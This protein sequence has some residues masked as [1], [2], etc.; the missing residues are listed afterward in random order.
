VIVG[1]A[2]PRC[3]IAAGSHVADDQN[4]YWSRKRPLDGGR[5]WIL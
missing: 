4:A 2:G 1:S 5:V 3:R